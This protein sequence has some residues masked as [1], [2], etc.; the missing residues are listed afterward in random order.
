[1]NEVTGI[2]IHLPFCRSKCNY[3]D[4]NSYPDKD[5][6][7]PAYFKAVEMELDSY[8][9]KLKHHR[10]NTIFIG[11]G[12]PS[13]VNEK[14]IIQLLNTC[15]RNFNISSNA[16][17]TIESNPGTLCRDKVKAYRQSGINRLSIGL[18]A[19]QDRILK[20]LGRTHTL[21]DYLNNFSLAREEGFDNIS[22]DLIFAIPGQTL[23]EWCE[24]L[25]NVVAMGPEHISCYSLQIE[26]GTVFG[27]L[28]SEGGLT[29]VDDE[30]D[31]EMYYRAKEILRNAGYEHYEISNFAKPGYQCK[32]NLIY[33]QT[34]Q[35]LG[36]G[37][38]AHSYIEG[39]RFN[40]VYSPEKYINLIQT[41][42]STVENVINIDR[43]EAMSEYMILGLRLIEGISGRDFENKFGVGLWEAF[44][45]PLEKLLRKGLIVIDP[46]K[47]NNVRLT[48][49]GLDLANQ[50]FVECIR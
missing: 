17:I 44:G 27:R 6:L 34:A 1:M 21:E 16:E 25:E 40:N 20:K 18:Q 5:N 35:Y 29:P 14:Y 19:W 33:W 39:K 23:E 10:I 31:R 38:G 13:Y 2:Y 11:G 28:F 3:C 4:F 15:R 24:T 47:G 46:E 9:N 50:V 37:A 42:K 49:K 8:G 43:E 7:I 12:T 22:T 36:V 32:H 48:E 41:G 26:E 45:V 30:Y